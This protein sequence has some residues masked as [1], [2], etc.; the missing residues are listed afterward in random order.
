[1]SFPKI[2]KL[3]HSKYLSKTWKDR[4]S[5]RMI[6]KNNYQATGNF[7]EAKAFMKAVS[8]LPTR[9]LVAVKKIEQHLIFSSEMINNALDPTYAYA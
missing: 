4:V 7:K 6:E 2:I 1:M 3:N 8:H 5:A 9:P